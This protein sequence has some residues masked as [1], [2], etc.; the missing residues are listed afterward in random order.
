MRNMAKYIYL[1]AVAMCSAGVYAHGPTNYTIDEDGHYHFRL[2]PETFQGE[3]LGAWDIKHVWLHD[4]DVVEFEESDSP[5][6]GGFTHNLT[7]SISYIGVK[8]DGS[9][10]DPS[11]VVFA[12]GEETSH[13]IG[14]QNLTNYF[15]NMTFRNVPLFARN[16]CPITIS[17][18]VFTSTT[19]QQSIR[20]RDASSQGYFTAI[21]CRF[22]N[23]ANTQGAVNGMLSFVATNCVFSCV[24]NSGGSVTSGGVIAGVSNLVLT[25]CTF[26]NCHLYGQYGGVISMSKSGGVLSLDRCSFVDNDLYFDYSDRRLGGGG[27]IYVYPGYATIR[28]CLFKGNN[29][30][31][32]TVD[33]NG[34]GGGAIMLGERNKAVDGAVI[35]N[36][37]FVENV[38]T[39]GGNHGLK[40]SGAIFVTADAPIGITNCIFHANRGLE[41][42]SANL[43]LEDWTTVGNCLESNFTYEDTTYDFSTIDTGETPTTHIVNGVNGN[44]VGDYNPR[45]AGASRGD[46][47]LQKTSPCCDAGTL[48]SWMDAD[49]LD[50]A[51]NARLVGDHPDMGCYERFSLAHSLVISVW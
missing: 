13:T 30:S 42:N 23:I 21:D 10:A 48:L 45:F 46:Y 17:N 12:Q 34:F 49:S 47:S 2:T 8:S 15:A 32:S 11:K 44:L 28:N 27:A 38:A 35:E 5:Y 7:K 33:T 26:E 14:C 40:G 20:A 4:N 19:I 6:V 50:L 16:T 18:C 37:T 24:T 25:C 29:A 1:A 41:A 22:E 9:P 3:F 31:R 43:R 39:A 36:C 51:G